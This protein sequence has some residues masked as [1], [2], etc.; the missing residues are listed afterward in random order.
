MIVQQKRVI[1]CYEA[2][3][4]FEDLK[5]VPGISLNSI[6]DVTPAW[7]DGYERNGEREI[8]GLYRDYTSKDAKVMEIQVRER[9]QHVKHLCGTIFASREG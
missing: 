9:I 3:A 5:M 4:R 7:L 6:S 2:E 8:A 1:A